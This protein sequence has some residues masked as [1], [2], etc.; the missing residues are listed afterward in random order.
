MKIAPEKFSLDTKFQ[1]YNLAFK[2]LYLYNDAEHLL[3]Y[4]CEDKTLAYIILIAPNTVV[5]QYF[6]NFH[7][8]LHFNTQA[9]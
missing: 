2:P 4:T 5:L 6:T 8:W 9:K 3:T 1:V 7:C